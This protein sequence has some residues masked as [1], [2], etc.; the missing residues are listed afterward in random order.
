MNGTPFPEFAPPS[1]EHVIDTYGLEIL[2][3]P[4]DWSIVDGDL[5]VTKDWDIQVG[6]TPYNALFRLVEEWRLNAPHLRHLFDLV[7]AMRVRRKELDDRMDRLGEEKR[8]RFDIRTYLKPDEQF[9]TAFHANIDE[10]RVADYGFATYAG[11]I[12]LILSG[13]LLRFRDDLDAKGDHWTKP[14]PL[15]N[16][17]SLGQVIVAAANGYRHDDEWSKTNLPTPQQMASQEVLARSLA[18]NVTSQPRAPGR[19]TEVL[20]ML[21][22]GKGFD[23][24]AA[25]LFTFVHNVALRRRTASKL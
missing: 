5:L 14:G 3:A 20:E 6:D 21:S 24:L 17:H 10:H 2:K 18:G 4:G 9:T 8:A 12:V 22:G 11:C 7:A 13:S 1:Y 15:F 23:G 16:A 25:N 19:C